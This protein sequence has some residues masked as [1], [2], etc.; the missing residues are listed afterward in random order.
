MK[1]LKIAAIIGGI[2][3]F[4][5]ASSACAQDDGRAI[6]I[7]PFSSISQINFFHSPALY[8]SDFNPKPDKAVRLRPD[9][10]TY[11]SWMMLIREKGYAGERVY[12]SYRDTQEKLA[13][14]R[15]NFNFKTQIT[16]NSNTNS[17]GKE[18]LREKWRDLLGVDIF[19]LYFKA[20]D[21]EEWVKDRLSVKVFH[22]KGRPQ[23]K[24][25][26]ISY[27]FRASF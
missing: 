9:Y 5:F 23:F 16:D 3:I 26:S 1:H 13:Y 21:V 2:V 17:D 19:Y 14:T 4:S 10:L 27:V 24:K 6:E 7:L 22:I 11:Y 8:L 18:V 12:V 15:Y 25:N 20:K